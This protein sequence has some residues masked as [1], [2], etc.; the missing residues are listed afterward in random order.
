MSIQPNIVGRVVEVE[1]P[2]RLHFGLFSFNAPHGTDFGGVG[3][4]IDRPATR[5]RMAEARQLNIAAPHSDRVARIVKKWTD[6]RA[7]YLPTDWRNPNSLPVRIGQSAGPAEHVGLGSG[8]QLALAI[9]AGLDRWFQ[10][11]VK[12]SPA[13]AIQLGRGRRS[14]VGIHGF[15]LGGLIIEQGK[16]ATNQVGE[17]DERIELPASWRVLLI[18]PLEQKGPGSDEE[19]KLFRGLPAV[20]PVDAA[21]LRQLVATQLMPSAR[22][23]DFGQFSRA[24]YELGY[25]SGLFY[26]LLQNGPFNGQAVQQVVNY[27]RVL[28]VVGVGQSSWG[29]CVY[30]IC[31]SESRA[32]DIESQLRQRLGE[33]HWMEIAQ[34]VR[35]GYAVSETHAEP[36]TM[37]RESNRQPR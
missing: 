6:L 35:R 13:D 11:P 1:A 18:C 37:E 29:P 4:M 21:R 7:D 23:G 19:E 25:R 17:F 9:A 22:A 34:P 5:V 31:E 8:T 30:A 2:S 36:I 32:Q 10:L 3:L 27:L 14:A 15:F 26:G 16:S 12:L 20:D 33:N 24:I 28:G